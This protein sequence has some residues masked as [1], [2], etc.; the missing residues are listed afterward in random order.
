MRSKEG[1]LEIR[2][3]MGIPRYF[4]LEVWKMELSM[5]LPRV[6]VKA[7]GKDFFLEDEG[8]NNIRWNSFVD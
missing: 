5:S 1:R 7:V 3:K 4:K 6:L 2:E 8:E